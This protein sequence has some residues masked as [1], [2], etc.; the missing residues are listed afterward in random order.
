MAPGTAGRRLGFAA[1]C[2]V[3]LLVSAITPTAQ[4]QAIRLVLTGQAMIRSDV[5]SHTPDITSTIAP[6]LQGDVVFT[7]YEATVGQKASNDDRGFLSPPESL[8]ALKALGFNLL[9][10]SNNHSFDLKVAGIQ[11]TL[12]EVKARDL[13]HAGIGNTLQEATAPGYLKT[14]KGTI[15]LVAMA[16]GLIAEGGMAAA[17]R[18]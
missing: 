16:S 11:N 1:V 7:N 17:D 14:P 4:S 13:A 12:R 18:P 10:L 3:A 6:L 5:R 9:A 15:A 2:L 8:D